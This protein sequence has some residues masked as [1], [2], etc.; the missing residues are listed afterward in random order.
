MPLNPACRAGVLAFRERIAFEMNPHVT[1]GPDVA[2]KCRLMDWNEDA[3][4]W[5]R[6]WSDTATADANAAEKMRRVSA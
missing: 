5:H 6:G 3:R 4:L 2:A 1:G